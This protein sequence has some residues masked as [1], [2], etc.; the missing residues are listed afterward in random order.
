M[1]ICI[2]ALVVF[3]IL[4]VFSASYRKIAKEAFS[5]IMNMLVFKPCTTKFDEKIKSRL[6][7]KL[8]K[9]PSLARFFYKNFKILSWIF[10]ITF[11]ASMFYSA[12]GIYNLVVYGSCQPGSTCIISQG[13]SQLVRIATCYEALTVY[14]IIAFALIAFLIIKYFK[15]KFKIV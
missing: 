13:G 1:V 6:T 9:V 15:I 8:M 4:G 3:S 7:I 11:F 2:V 10:T 12:Y 14:G 5:C